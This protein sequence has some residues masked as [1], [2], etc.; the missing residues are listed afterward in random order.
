MNPPY[1]HREN[2]RVMIVDDEEAIGKAMCRLLIM[3][4]I[5]F[6]YKTNAQDALDLLN[7]S[8]RP[9]SLILSDQRM[10]GM[11]GIE[12]LA[13]VRKIRPQPLRFLVTAYSDCEIIIDSINK[14]A[15]HKYILKPWDDE[16]LMES[17][18]SGL[19]QYEEILERDRLFDIAKEKNRK[20]YRLDSDLMEIAEKHERKINGMGQNI[21]RFEKILAASP[22]G[23]KETMAKMETAL[24]GKT[25]PDAG[26]FDRLF[27][28]CQKALYTECHLLTK[29]LP[30]KEIK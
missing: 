23:I 22:G 20:L 13:R 2:H 5:D 28:Y 9:F 16:D 14:G 7:S 17:I 8:E 15:V 12:F 27:A 11:Q 25:L 30:N 19:K 3:A 24:T 6:T 10:P 21:S 26:T 18:R 4:D 1:N 29:A